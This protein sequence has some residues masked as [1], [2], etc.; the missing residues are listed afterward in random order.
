MGAKQSLQRYQDKKT[1]EAA[2]EGRLDGIAVSRAL[3]EARGLGLVRLPG[4]LVAR[5]ADAVTVDVSEN[6][7][8]SFPASICTLGSLQRLVAHDNRLHELPRSFGDLFSLTELD[9]SRNMLE[10]HLPD[11]IASLR[12][13]KQLRLQQNSIKSLPDDI[14]RLTRLTHLGLDHNVIRAIPQSFTKVRRN[15]GLLSHPCGPLSLGLSLS[16]AARDTE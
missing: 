12:G 1:V 14:G 6:R 5:M 15:D 9:L 8:D 16:I 7:F 11:S 10:G 2:A 4:G 3:F 13:L